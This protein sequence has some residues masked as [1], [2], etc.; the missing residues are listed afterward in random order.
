MIFTGQKMLYLTAK[1]LR[2]K[3]NITNQPKILQLAIKYGQ[4]GLQARFDL[5]VY[6][7][8]QWDRLSLNVDTKEE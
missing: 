4:T 2:H 6:V 3:Q 8:T 1:M 5:K 7:L